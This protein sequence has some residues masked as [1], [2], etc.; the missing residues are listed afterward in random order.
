MLRGLLFICM[1][2]GCF[3]LC[4]F[5]T[6][7]AL[8]R[9]IT[10]NL[11]NEKLNSAL[12][13]IQEQTGLIFSYSSSILN[14]APPI[15]L[16]LKQKT[17]REALALMLPKSISFKARNNYII[18]KEKPVE[19]NPEKTKLS[20]Y[21]YDKNTDKKLAN[22]T[23]YDKNTLQSVTTN[24]YGYYS[25]SLP[26]EDQCLTVN[27]ENYRD[28][29]VSL[30]YLKEGP[31]TNIS[32]DPV[33]DTTSRSDSTFWRQTIRDFS[34]ST[35]E[36]FRRFKGYINTINV[37]DTL[38]RNFQVSLFP[39]L[40][41]NGLM[42]GNVYNRYSLNVFGGYSRGTH[43]VELGGFFNI[44]REKVTGIQAAGFF[45]I[46]GDTM[47]GVQLAGSF[48]VTGKSM[49][50]VQAAGLLNLNVGH[51]SGLQMAGMANL[52]AKGHSGVSL[53][54]LLNANR[55]SVRGVQVAGM[56]NI[57][58]DTLAGVSG[59][60]LMNL[61]WY[62]KQSLEIA[63]VLNSTRFGDHNV[64]IAGFMN[65]TARGS[66]DLQVAALLN[67]THVLK[68]LQIGMFNY[69]D[70]AS[71]IPIGLL[72]FVK[73]G[74]HQLEVSAD[75]LFYI[76]TTFRTGVRAF[77]NI[78]TAGVRPGPAGNLWSIG[79]GIGTSF[80]IKKQFRGEATA[81]S[82]HVSVGDFYFATS[83]LYRFYL[84][85]EY[86]LAKNM[87][88]AAGPTFNL[89]WSDTLLPGYES[90]YSKIAPYYSFNKALANDFNLKGW[91]GARVAIR[92]F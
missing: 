58:A 6:I 92:F 28:T 68:G 89:Y 65:N 81:S 46:V 88:V 87:S 74:L 20:G 42:S 37:K 83:E 55:F 14:N 35:N 23:I 31:L 5:T 27:K 72:S 30:T 53:A 45:N 77:H 49:K 11:S 67:R 41:T 19:K 10:L 21:I 85:V 70:S 7:P 44:D 3:N 71:G 79:Y 36:L 25:I 34:Q 76:N 24:E 38:S 91:F 8:E 63:G 51:G 56:L 82:H 75:E 59:A 9:E 54:G 29:C 78:L 13:K 73:K 16:H 48:N 1:V 12:N 50:G 64:Q 61:N 26:K 80:R 22:V 90:T 84:G 2:A 17:V 32:I 39:F 40:G 62:G 47:H 66:S 86:R 18:L 60:G 15:S 43:L 52:N 69:A 4:A 33:S 57:T